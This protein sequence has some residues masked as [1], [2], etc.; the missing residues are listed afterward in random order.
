M[1][2]EY[3]IGDTPYRVTV[4]GPLDGACTVTLQ[5]C[6]KDGGEPRTLTA[7]LVP[8]ESGRYLFVIDGHHYLTHVV[9]GPD[10]HH[11]SIAGEQYDVIPPEQLERQR[12]A[13]GSADAANHV[14]PPM[15]GQVVTI[16]VEDGDTVEQGQT[17]VVVSAMKMETNLTAPYAGTVTAINTTVGAQVKPGDVLVDIEADET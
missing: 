14:T 12:R 16:L 9:A 1:S 5:P 4:D 8:V 7:R 15:P 2:I 13:G 10:A 3:Q 11:V 6:G 17:V